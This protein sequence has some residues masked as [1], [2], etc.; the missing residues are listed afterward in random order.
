MPYD[1][2]SGRGFMVADLHTVEAQGLQPDLNRGTC[3]ECGKNHRKTEKPWGD[4]AK[5]VGKTMGQP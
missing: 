4:H 3:A 5:I 1:P 2:C